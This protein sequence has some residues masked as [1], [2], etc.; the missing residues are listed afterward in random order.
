MPGGFSRFLKGFS[1]LAEILFPFAERMMPNI[2][3]AI[4]TF[5][6]VVARHI[7]QSLFAQS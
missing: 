2:N 6:V 7:L 1:E 4:V 3:T 5:H